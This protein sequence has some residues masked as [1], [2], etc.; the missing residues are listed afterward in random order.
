[1]NTVWPQ[2]SSP[3]F[4]PS[5]PPSPS[6][7]TWTSATVSTGWSMNISAGCR[8]SD[9]ITP[10][11]QGWMPVFLKAAI[12]LSADIALPN[13]LQTSWQ[14]LYIVTVWFSGELVSL[15]DI[16]V[17][18]FIGPKQPTSRG[19]NMWLICAGN[20]NSTMFRSLAHSANPTEACDLWPSNKRNT[21]WPSSEEHTLGNFPRD[22]PWITVSLTNQSQTPSPQLLVLPLPSRLASFASEQKWSMAVLLH[23]WHS[24]NL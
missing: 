22:I 10:R 15:R 23:Q 18:F 9:R 19:W 17:H 20:M 5:P 11:S 12:K 2:T 6:S 3:P 21:F 16:H 8:L 14:T 1:M 4:P 13:T 7:S 24:H